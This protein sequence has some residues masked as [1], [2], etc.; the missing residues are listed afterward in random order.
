MIE[1]RPSNERNVGNW[2]SAN[3]NEN[4][5]GLSEV[6]F[7]DED[8]KIIFAQVESNSV[9]RKI[10]EFSSSSRYWLQDGV[11]IGDDLYL[12][13]IIVKAAVG[14]NALSFQVTNVNMIKVP[15]IEGRP[16]LEAQEQFATPLYHK[17]D[18]NSLTY[19]GAGVINNTKEGG[20]LNPDGYIYVYG[21]T[22]A[23]KLL[24]VARVKPED[25]EDFNVWEFYAD[26]DD[27]SKDIRDAKGICNHVSSELSVSSITV[28][29]EG[30]FVLVYM[31]DTLSGIISYVVAD[32][33]YGPFENPHDVYYVEGLEGEV[34]SYNAKAHPHLSNKGELLVSYNVNSMDMSSFEDGDIY[35]PRFINLIEISKR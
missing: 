6:R 26:N 1:I 28:N 20:S 2:G 23:N 33:P 11:V 34:F 9:D 21:H 18:F 22:G 32:T 29:T 10:S 31:K 5:F 12:F 4:R 15:L 13:P 24:A 25:I 30:K 8:G 14:G 27:W 17:D 7:F 19:F 16:N 35:R 3:D